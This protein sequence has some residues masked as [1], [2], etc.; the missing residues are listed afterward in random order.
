M[1]FKKPVRLVNETAWLAIR[2]PGGSYV[3]ITA[4]STPEAFSV[5]RTGWSGAGNGT[6]NESAWALTVKVPGNSISRPSSIYSVLLGAGSVVSVENGLSHLGIGLSTTDRSWVLLSDSSAALD[7]R[8]TI[9]ARFPAKVTLLLDLSQINT[10]FLPSGQEVDAAAVLAQDRSN[11]GVDLRLRL[12]A[13]LRKEISAILAIPTASTAEKFAFSRGDREGVI[14]AS[15]RIFPASSSLSAL[16]PSASSDLSSSTDGSFSTE[17]GRSPAGLATILQELS[18]AADASALRSGLDTRAIETGSVRWGPDSPADAN[19][20]STEGQ[21]I[22]I[23]SLATV[24]ALCLLVLI[25]HHARRKPSSRFGDLCSLW[26]SLGSITADFAFVILFLGRLSEYGYR[27]PYIAGLVLIATTAG[28]NLGA[29]LA[30]FFCNLYPRLVPALSGSPESVNAHETARELAAWVESNMFIVAPVLVC[31]MAS[32]DNSL[33][34]SSHFMGLNCFSAPLTI[35]AE[36]RMRLAGS[37]RLLLSSAPMLILN[38]FVLL[39]V[40]ELSALNFASIVLSILMILY[41]VV[42][43]ITEWIL[44]VFQ[45]AQPGGIAAANEKRRSSGPRKSQTSEHIETHI[46]I[47]TKRVSIQTSEPSYQVKTSVLVS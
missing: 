21:A 19:L 18:V 9:R 32:A 26:L 22:T 27:A 5:G 47:S 3:N 17:D 42:R 12:E 39:S 15:F 43:K 31:N 24:F 40:G 23:G 11:S 25:L 8:Y 14:Q 2:N 28:V 20:Q 4:A 16:S 41:G 1:L 44:F 7:L 33:V 36:R 45:S 10:R 35:E 37:I 29:G 46:T 30:L 13:Q 6:R 34:L 38:I